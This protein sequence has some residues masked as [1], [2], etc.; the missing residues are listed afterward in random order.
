M[1]IPVQDIK[2]QLSLI[3]ERR[4]QIAH[5]ADIDPTCPDTRCPINQVFVSEKVDFLEQVVESIHKVCNPQMY[6]IVKLNVSDLST[7]EACNLHK[8]IASPIHFP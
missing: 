1:D 8:F 7:G 5:E 3:I 6:K 4:D 2:E